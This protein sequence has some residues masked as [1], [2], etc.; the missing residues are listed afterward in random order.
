MV[1]S[2]AVLVLVIVGFFCL[3]AVPRVDAQREYYFGAEWAQIWINS[4]GSVDL[5]YNVS[6]TLD[7]GQE[8]NWVSVG[9]PQGDFTIGS[10][11]DQ[12]GNVLDTSDISSGSDYNVRVDFDSPL[13]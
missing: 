3:S 2:C 12:Y 10:A 1:K 4:D 6:L 5:F 11:L 7:S 8:I 9:Q 13:K